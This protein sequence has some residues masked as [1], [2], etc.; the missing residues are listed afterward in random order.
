MLKQEWSNTENLVAEVLADLKKRHV[1]AKVGASISSGLATTIRLKEVE[2]VE[3]TK[4]KSLSITVYNGKCKGSVSTTDFIPSAVKNSIDAACRIATYTEEDPYSGLVD[5]ELLAK[6]ILDLDLYHPSCITPLDAI[7]KAKSCEMAGL[8][9]DTAITNSEGASFSSNEK[10]QVYGNTHGFIGSICS[11]SYSLSCVLIAKDPKTGEMQRDYDFTSAR[12]VNDLVTGRQIGISAA[13]RTLARLGARKITTCQ[14]PVIFSHTIAPGLFRSFIAAISGEALYRK[15][16]FLLDHL[17]KQIF[18]DFISM[19]EQPHILQGLYSRAFD[20]EG[21]PTSAHKI[22]SDGMLN[23][24]LL[25]SYSA[26][27]LGMQPTGH[28]G[29]VHNLQ[30]K[31]K[32]N[33]TFNELVKQMHRGLIVT[34]LM[35]SGINL[36]TGDYSRGASGFWVENG[37]ILY[38]VHE[39]TVA[40]NLKELFKNIVAIGTDLETRTNIRTGSILIEN[41]MVAGD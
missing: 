34:E 21:L 25:S 16:S 17:G 24:Y 30:V 8:E 31:S 19:Q 26:R 18:P 39:I 14:V 40:G 36:V 4:D 12:R 10:F 28:L 23:T 15:S 37:Q 32:Q 22:I 2:T 1:A 11:T 35:G 20:G 5:K 9:Y 27:K 13:E 6:Q 41:M 7:E 33:Y 29:G 38:P 3:F